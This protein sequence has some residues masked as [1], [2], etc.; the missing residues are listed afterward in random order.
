[1]WRER[2]ERIF[3]KVDKGKIVTIVFEMFE[4]VGGQRRK[5]AVAECVGGCW[6]GR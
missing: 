3:P 2:R 1:M 5:R 6:S 4:R